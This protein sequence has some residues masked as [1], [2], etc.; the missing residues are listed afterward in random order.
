MPTMVALAGSV[1]MLKGNF[2]GLKD[3]FPIMPHAA[4]ALAEAKRR[5]SRVNPK[6]MRRNIR[7]LR[8]M[9]GAR[10]YGVMDLYE[11]FIMV[12][13]LLV[14]LR[15]ESQDEFPDRVSG[16][17]PAPAREMMGSLR[18]EARM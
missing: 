13:L 4:F 3:L 18:H 10:K 16:S 14:S 7:L 2:V 9:I 17:A 15:P 5:Q 6:S 11:V 1:C 8:E 12:R